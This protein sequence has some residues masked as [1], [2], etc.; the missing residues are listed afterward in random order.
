MTAKQKEQCNAAPFCFV[1]IYLIDTKLS[2]N[3]PRRIDD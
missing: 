1:N 3:E 2:R